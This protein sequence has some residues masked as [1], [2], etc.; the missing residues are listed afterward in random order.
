MTTAQLTL[1][2]LHAAIAHQTSQLMEA[3]VKV[4]NTYSARVEELMD[5]YE[6]W[7]REDLGEMLGRLDNIVATLRGTQVPGAAIVG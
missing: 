5:R 4:E 7:R 3:L 6:E 1:Y 2:D